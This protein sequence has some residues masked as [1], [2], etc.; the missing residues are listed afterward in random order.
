MTVWNGCAQLAIYGGPGHHLRR[1][2][3]ID[4]KDVVP[5]HMRF[6]LAQV[7]DRRANMLEE[8]TLSHPQIGSPSDHAVGIVRAE[9]RLGAKFGDQF[10]IHVGTGEHRDLDPPAAALADDGAAGIGVVPLV[11]AEA[12]GHNREYA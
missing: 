4:V 3:G 5:T 2:P 11:A 10:R 1:L 9:E 8:N 7:L 12:G 6:E